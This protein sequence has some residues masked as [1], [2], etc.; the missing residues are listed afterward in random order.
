MRTVPPGH[1]APKL[2]TPCRDASTMD[3]LPPSETIL[4]S[5]NFSSLVV[6]TSDAKVS[7]F[8]P[9]LS[10]VTFFC[11]KPYLNASSKTKQKCWI[12]FSWH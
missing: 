6:L 10:N 8:T 5:L 2:R 4:W 7:D 9:F 3:I 1:G 11:P 12:A